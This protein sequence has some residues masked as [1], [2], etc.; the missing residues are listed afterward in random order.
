MPWNLSW[1]TIET[2][3]KHTWKFPETSLKLYWNTLETFLKHPWN[4]LEA[5]QKPFWN[6]LETSLKHLWNFPKFF[7]I[8][9]FLILM[10]FHI[11]VLGK[12]YLVLIL[13]IFW[14]PPLQTTPKSFG[15][16]SLSLF[17]ILQP[18]MISV[19]SATVDIINRKVVSSSIFQAT[20]SLA[21]E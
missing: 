18:L 19:Y 1:N 13:I 2:F 5:P 11:R 6:T 21:G 12:F 3:L 8:K 16:L 9:I 7:F 17:T 4:F 10:T 20:S 14:G 15:Y